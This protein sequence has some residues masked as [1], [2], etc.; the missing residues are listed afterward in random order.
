MV[1]EGQTSKNLRGD[2]DGR[3][4]RSSLNRK[5]PPF[6]GLGESEDQ[7]SKKWIIPYPLPPRKTCTQSQ[8]SLRNEALKATPDG[9]GEGEPTVRSHW[10]PPEIAV[11]WCSA[12]HTWYLGSANFGEVDF[13]LCPF[14]EPV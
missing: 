11:L 4:F 8:V 13:W 12:G 14:G 3:E 6:E 5:R 1:L 2:L 10:D 7:G 9:K